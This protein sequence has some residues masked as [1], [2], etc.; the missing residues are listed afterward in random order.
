MMDMT[1]SRVMRA[2][3]ALVRTLALAA[4]TLVLSLI[5]VSRPAY[6]RSYEIDRVDIDAT[7]MEDGTISVVEVREFDFE[8][9]FNG[10]YWEIP[11]GRY[12]GRDVEVTVLYGG[13]LENGQVVPFDQSESE[14]NHTY[15]VRDYSNEKELK[16]FC[17]ADDEVVQFVIAYEVTGITSRWADTGELYWKYVSDGWDEESQNVTMTLHLPV[18]DGVTVTPGD[19]VRAW[20]H[21]P[22]DGTVS[23]SGNDIVYYSPGVGG[24]EFAEARVAFP[25]DWLPGEEQLS[26]AKLETILSE[27]QAWADEANARRNRAK[28][29]MTGGTGVGIAAI[30]ASLVASIVHTRKMRELNR[31]AFDD[32]YFRDV[33]TQ[34]HPA[35]LGALY[36]RG[37]VDTNAFTATLM[38]LTDR[39]LVRLA[40]AKVT[41]KKLLGGEK[42]EDDYLL[43]Q[44]D[45]VRR[46]EGGLSNEQRLADAIDDEAMNFLFNTC[47]RRAY[48]MSSTYDPTVDLGGEPP[49]YFSML[50]KVAKKHPSAYS[51]AYEGWES[52]V[53][54]AY[55]Q[56]FKGHEGSSGSTGWMTLLFVVDVLIAIAFLFFALVTGMNLLAAILIFVGLVLSS[57][58]LGFSAW[59]WEDLNREGRETKAKLA[60]LRRWLLDFTRLKEAIPD[61][62]VLWNRLLVM[63]AALGVAEEVVKQLKVA[64]PHVLNDPYMRGVYGWYYYDTYSR[65]R[66]S[67]ASS[68]GEHVTS[69]HSIT[70]SELS[71][72]SF[73]SGGGGGGGF[74]GGGGGGFGGGGGGGA[75]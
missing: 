42:V 13:V 34:D 31:T 49:L 41:H 26:T 63:A 52:Q 46:G 16:I 25:A 28:V 15:Q 70:T 62:V 53:S 36:N 32:E 5:C 7:V 37:S 11:E 39:K 29:I 73:S 75:F 18:P 3:T 44:T 22:L 23:F 65:S 55:E 14:E 2:K 21:G 68:I 72:S 66:V 4:I 9:H 69:A 33:P 64:L 38:R 45:F 61:D 54:A 6:A 57:I 58:V 40:R 71:S 74:S 47:A 30:V 48:S 56:R 8:G 20:G 60:A 12:E 27:E 43:T 35:V 51:A 59:G 24:D 17:Q 1:D 50:E 10:V 19:N 67:P